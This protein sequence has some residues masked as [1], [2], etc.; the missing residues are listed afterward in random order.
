MLN[1]RLPLRAL[2]NSEIPCQVEE[3]SMVLWVV[4]AVVVVAVVASVAAIGWRLR[5]ILDATDDLPPPTEAR[6]TIGKLRELAGKVAQQV[7][8]HTHKVEEISD[9]LAAI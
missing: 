8:E 9:E 5:A 1:S 3:R 4:I 2:A 7:D 6:E